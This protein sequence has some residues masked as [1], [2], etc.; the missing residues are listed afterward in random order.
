MMQHKLVLPDDYR[1]HRGWNW[2][3]LRMIADSGLFKVSTERFPWV[4]V[5]GARNS[6]WTMMRVNGALVG[7]D[8]WDTYS[9]TSAFYNSG[10]FNEGPL[11]DLDLVIKIQYYKCPFWDEFQTNTGIPVKPWTVMPTKDFPLG[12]FKW[13][14]E[15]HPLM[16]TITGKNNRFGRQPWVDWCVKQPDFY[17]KSDY[18]S[19]DSLETYRDILKR[20]RWGII[21][22]GKQRNHDGKNRRECEFSSCGIPLALTY[23]PTYSFPMNPGE[24]FVLLKNPED[25]ATLRYIDPR[26]YAKASR[27]LYQEH[28]SPQGAAKTLISLVKDL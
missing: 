23:Q 19:T 9:P 18:I 4:R 3:L 17:A 5:D 6:N 12:Y 27:Y 10:F 25:L 13:K 1:K 22:K 7:L 26:P 20:C 24:H 16:G 11:K 15:N 14:H 8:T 21:L 28:F 2:T